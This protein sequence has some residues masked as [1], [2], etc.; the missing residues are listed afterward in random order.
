MTLAIR[1]LGRPTIERSTG[2]TPIVRGHKA[3]ALLA[4]LALA[5]TPVPR[6][7]L[8]DLLFT[9]ADDPLGALRWNLS[10][11]RRLLGDA[12]DVGGDPVRLIL[13]I[14]TTVDADVVARGSWVEAVDVPGLG[15]PLLAGMSFD[16]SP[17]FQF[18]LDGERRHLLAA[19]E[20]VLQD[21]ARSRLVRGNAEAAIANASRLIELNP[22]D[23]N[24]HVL[25]ILAL[26]AAGASDQAAE[27][28]R[29]Y[30]A[31]LQRELGVDPGPALRAAME[32]PS[33]GAPGVVDRVAVRTRID[34]GASAVRVG[35]LAAGLDTLRRAVWD[36][37]TLD[38]KA[39][40]ARALITLG[41]ALVHAARGTDEE[42]AAALLE[43]ANL[44]VELGDPESA[45]TAQREL[46]YIALLRGQY[47]RSLRWL[48]QAR[49]LAR[50]EPSHLAWV[51]L[52]TGKAH[53]DLG[54]HALAHR[55]L[56]IAIT[57]ASDVG[58][59][60]CE[61][62][63]LASLARLR[64]LREEWDEAASALR[65]S[66]RL[67]KEEDWL[68]FRPYP[69]ALLGEVR[70]G[71]GDLDAAAAAFDSAYALSRQVEDPCWESLAQRGAG[72]VAIR[73]GDHERGLELLGEAPRVCLRLPDTYMWIAAYALD[74]R[75]SAAIDAKAPAALRWLGELE[76]FSARHE[77]NELLARAAVQRVQLGEPGAVEIARA[78]V[79]D[80]DNPALSARLA[81]S[82][83]SL[84]P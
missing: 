80:V 31:L 51:E 58:D 17:A 27:Q 60:R 39:L 82:G 23:E 69:E 62:F 61:S 5:E 12:A 8:V 7:R 78:L 37:R 71:T 25:L 75:S 45:S 84:K 24:A 4:Y 10:Q 53:T 30:R 59:R 48:D 41:S 1:L 36:A 49:E 9:D 56:D 42:G 11:L 74:A 6:Q 32:T 73:R 29:T 66:L 57:A 64:I 52:V 68:S 55:H 26:R 63:A 47:S 2:E 35:A 65:R 20:A 72:L 44:A 3:W 70:L 46:G 22:L 76:A 81:L 19:S 16:S 43:G 38:N 34:A 13:P 50:G 18:W 33:L 40:L 54:R 15:L 77:M 67:A 83:N 28:A 21:A 79:A 14:G